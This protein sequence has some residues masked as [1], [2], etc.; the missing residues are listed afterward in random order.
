MATSYRKAIFTNRRHL[1]LL[2]DKKKLLENDSYLQ[3]EFLFLFMFTTFCVKTSMTSAFR[4]TDTVHV[5][6]F[7]L[8]KSLPSNKQMDM[9]NM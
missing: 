1:L 4:N 3:Y 7:T 6:C 9:S 8:F 2:Q 5:L